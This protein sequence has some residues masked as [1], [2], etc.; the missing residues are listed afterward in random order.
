MGG[1]EEGASDLARLRFG[2][3]RDGI[4]KI[5]DQRVGTAFQ[6]LLLLPRA[7]TWH[8]KEGAHRQPVSFAGAERLRI[9]AWRLHCATRVPSCL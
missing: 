8:E 4:L 6:A 2:V 9:K 7:V 3:K 5:E 1:I